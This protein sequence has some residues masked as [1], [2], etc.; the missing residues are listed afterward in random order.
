MKKYVFLIIMLLN[1]TLFAQI[2]TTIFPE[3]NA[4]EEFTFLNKINKENIPLYVMPSFNLDSI[5]QTERELDEKGVGRPFRFGYAFDVDYG[6][7]HGKWFEVENKNVWSIRFKSKGAYSLNFRLSNLKL[8]NNSE[9]YVYSSNGT[10]VYGPV[11]HKENSTIEFNSLGT[12]IIAGEEV[13][14]QIIELKTINLNSTVK[15]SNVIHGFVNHYK[16][17]LSNIDKKG[18]GFQSAELTCHNDVM[19]HSAFDKYSRGVAK[20]IMGGYLCRGTL[21]NNTMGTN[22]PYIY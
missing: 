19:C 7:E 18:D 15:I 13:I 22:R 9:L 17:I 2:K 14:I 11:T 12:D 4:F 1:F 21:L 10:V 16:D 6:M 3:C 5:I 20:L 8:I